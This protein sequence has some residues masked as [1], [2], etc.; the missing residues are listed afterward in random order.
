MS[1][2]SRFDHKMWQEHE[3]SKM[4]KDGVPFPMLSDAEKSGRMDRGAQGLPAWAEDRGGH[5]FGLAAGSSY[6][7]AWSGLGRQGLGALEALS[8][9]GGGLTRRIVHLNRGGET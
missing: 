6:A 2:D 8:E 5:P 1:T 4:V 3:L 7:E 9:Q